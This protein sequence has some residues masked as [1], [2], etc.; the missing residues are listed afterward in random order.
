MEQLIG[1]G[2]VAVF[3]FIMWIIHENAQAALDDP[4]NKKVVYLD[5]L[6][7]VTELQGRG[8]WS[9]TIIRQSG[10]FHSSKEVHGDAAAALAAA[11]S[12]FRRAKIDGIGIIKNETAELHFGRL[13][14]NHR[15][16]N[17]GKKVG[18]A[19]VRLVKADIPRPTRVSR[20]V[21]TMTCDCGAPTE[22]EAD[23][24]DGDLPCSACGKVVRLSPE[25]V[26]EL[27][28]SIAAAVRD[29]K[30]RVEAGEDS[31]EIEAKLPKVGS[32]NT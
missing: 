29:A 17:E 26:D 4:N 14:H 6:P 3:A 24:L 27:Q 28:F 21:V 8:L 15:G 11:V 20:L 2:L 25:R 32:T 9:I 19:I 10:N 18:Q 23:R 13:F 22:F 30:A 12:T 16:S 7:S 1:L 5:Q 31:V